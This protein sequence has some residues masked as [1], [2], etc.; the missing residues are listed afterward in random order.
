[1]KLLGSTSKAVLVDLLLCLFK[2]QAWYFLIRGLIDELTSGL[3]SENTINVIKILKELSIKQHVS[4]VVIIQIIHR[5]SPQVIELFNWLIL[6]SRG[7]LIQSGYTSSLS[8]FYKLNYCEALPVSTSIADDLIMNA[9]SFDSANQSAYTGEQ[10]SLGTTEAFED[11][12]QEPSSLLKPSR[13][14]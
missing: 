6:L 2:N 11:H 5:P 9:S 13:A 1:M 14:K 7:R 3:D 12:H 10:E 8:A 4:S